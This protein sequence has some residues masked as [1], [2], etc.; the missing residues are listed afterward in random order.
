[1]KTRFRVALA[2]ALLLAGLAGPLLASADTDEGLAIQLARS[3]EKYYGQN[4]ARVDSFLKQKY[5]IAGPMKK[6]GNKYTY[7]VPMKSPTC[8]SLLLFTDDNK[9][10]DWHAMTWDRTEDNMYGKACN[11][12][13]RHARR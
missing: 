6:E 5:G 13:F 8:G 3:I 9:V 10:V 1:M 11:E 2:A 4:L 7:M 12:A